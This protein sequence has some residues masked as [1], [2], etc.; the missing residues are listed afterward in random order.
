M[1]LNHRHIRLLVDSMSESP[2][3]SIALSKSNNHSKL[4]IKFIVTLK[5]YEIS[6]QF[7]YQF[8]PIPANSYGQTEYDLGLFL[9]CNV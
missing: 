3:K 6:Y 8:Q 7:S 4:N 9:K 5:W 2:W 1:G